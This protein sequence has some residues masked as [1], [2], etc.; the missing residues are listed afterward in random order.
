MYKDRDLFDFELTFEDPAAGKFDDVLVRYNSSKD[1]KAGIVRI[2]AKHRQP[3]LNDNSNRDQQKS[4]TNETISDADLLTTKKKQKQPFSIS[5]Y[6]ESFLGIDKPKSAETR[7]YIICTNKTLDKSVSILTRVNLEDSCIPSIMRDIHATFYCVKKEKS[8]DTILKGVAVGKGYTGKDGLGI[9]QAFY[10]NFIL[11]CGSANETMLYNIVMKLLMQ[12]VDFQHISTYEKMHV[13]MF[14]AINRGPKSL[15]PSDVTKMFKLSESGY[16]L[17]YFRIDTKKHVESLRVKYFDPKL[18]STVLEETNL[19]QFLK[20]TKP[21]TH[22]YYSS[23]G[24]DVS[25]LVIEQIVNLA[26]YEM[27]LFD[28]SAHKESDVLNDLCAGISAARNHCVNEVNNF[29]R[30]V[31]TI[32]TQGKLF[33]TDNYT[34]LATEYDMK[35]IIVMH[36]TK[37]EKTFD[38]KTIDSF[39][40]G[41]LTEDTRNQL[42]VKS[43]NRFTTSVSFRKVVN[44]S[45]PLPYVYD[46]LESNEKRSKSLHKTRYEEIR[47][48]YVGRRFGLYDEDS[49]ADDSNYRLESSSEDED[50]DDDHDNDDVF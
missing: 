50:E 32:I 11:A 12:L 31:I 30:Q 42:F 33:K 18:N 46:L 36:I 1:S 37:D 39:C 17:E 34:Q 44:L 43:V 29:P 16:L 25:I 26:N 22:W 9:I 21:G 14:E 28:H 24:T 19:F 23:C 3:T 27:V 10:D 8:L 40:V 45:D 47:Q 7:K 5:M 38:D 48:W 13:C 4:K 20:T 2:Q 15:K 35:F 49:T 41:D 6:F